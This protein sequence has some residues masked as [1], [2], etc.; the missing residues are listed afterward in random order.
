MR[1]TKGLGNKR[2]T[3]LEGCGGHRV[4]TSG[5]ACRRREWGDK[6]EREREKKGKEGGR[7]ERE[8]AGM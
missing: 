1:K 2:V 8:K 3:E 4:E 5:S 6:E 7:G